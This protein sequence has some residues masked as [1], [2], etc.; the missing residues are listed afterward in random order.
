MTPRCCRYTANRRQISLVEGHDLGIAAD[1]ND[2]SWIG[3]VRSCMINLALPFLNG[4]FLGFGEI[5]AHEVAFMFGWR[6]ASL[7]P[8]SRMGLE[9]GHM[10]GPGVAVSGRRSPRQDLAL[11]R[12]LENLTSME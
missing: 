2:R 1:R 9:T 7:R 12:E 6:G 10:V 3:I 4:V 5:F 11:D 8:A